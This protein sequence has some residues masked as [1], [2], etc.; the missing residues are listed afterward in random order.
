MSYLVEI[1]RVHVLT[2]TAKQTV[3]DLQEENAEKSIKIYRWL[4]FQ[5]GYVSN[6]FSF[7]H[8]ER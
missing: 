5:F 3:L 2:C 8:L 1:Y 7:K 6:W 4:I